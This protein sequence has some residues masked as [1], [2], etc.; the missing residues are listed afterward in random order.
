MCPFPLHFDSAAN[1]HYHYHSSVFSS[2]YIKHFFSSHTS[3]Q[4]GIVECIH[5]FI[6]E[7]THTLLIHANVY[8]YLKFW[9]Y[10]VHDAG[11]LIN[12]MSY[13]DSQSK[14]PSSIFFHDEPLVC[15]SPRVFGFT[16]LFMVL[17]QDLI[18]CLLV[19]L[20][21]FSLIIRVQIRYVTI[22]STCILMLHSLKIHISLHLPFQLPSTDPSL[23]DGP[24]D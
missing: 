24:S 10:A 13:F 1:L 11:Y 16:C 22:V 17:L 19:Q 4:H 9:R 21:V 3:E 23:T 12:I 6:F 15:I 18:N 2:S 7:T 14:V 20:N 5:C 8:F